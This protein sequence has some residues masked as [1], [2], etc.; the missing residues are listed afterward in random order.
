MNRF[1]YAFL[2]LTL[3]TQVGCIE[4]ETIAD[5]LVDSG[6]WDLTGH[7]DEFGFVLFKSDQTGTLKV[8][9]E[10]VV[11]FPCMN[12]LPFTWTVDESSGL[13]TVRYSNESSAMVVCSDNNGQVNP[14]IETTVVTTTSSII[15]LFGNVFVN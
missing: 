8:N 4:K 13:L 1:R 7:C 6:Y 12:L 2:L 14:A 9:D 10:C 11:G 5:H 15:S 3:A